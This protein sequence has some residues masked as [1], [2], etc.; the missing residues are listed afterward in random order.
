MYRCNLDVW[1]L[2]QKPLRWAKLTRDTEM[3]YNN[4]MIFF[5][6]SSFVGSQLNFLRFCN[7]LNVKSVL[8]V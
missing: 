5:E 1:A 3:E 7:Y 2:A 6:T 8:V 4:D